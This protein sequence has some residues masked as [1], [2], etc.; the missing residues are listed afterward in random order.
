MERYAGW[1]KEP[2]E[3]LLSGVVMCCNATSLKEFMK[4]KVRT[5]TMP[6]SC[7]KF[8]PIVE[9]N[10]LSLL[11]HPPNPSKDLCTFPLSGV[12]RRIL[13]FRPETPCI[14]VLNTGGYHEGILLGWPPWVG[15]PRAG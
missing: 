3:K 6:L 11:V 7:K 5:D 14:A 13:H 1:A 4:L 8:H 2:S 15:S 9:F 12:F 10:C